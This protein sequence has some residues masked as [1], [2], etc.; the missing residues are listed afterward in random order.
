MSEIDIEVLAN[1]GAFRLDATAHFSARGITVVL[2]PSG[3]GKTTLLRVLAGLEKQV[4][5]S[6]RI[7]DEQWLDSKRGIR[8]ATHERSIGYIFQEARLFP[9]LSVKGN[10]DFAQRRGKRRARQLDRAQII[11]I[12]GIK[13]LLDR[14]C[15]AL[16]GGEIQRVAIAR[17]LLTN[18]QLLLMDEPLSALDLV[19]R[20]EALAY[21]E[22]IPDVFGIPI[23]YV[24][25]A[26]EEAS[27]VANQLAIMNNG[28]IIATGPAQEIVAR[29]DLAPYLGRF[30]AGAILE[31]TV[32]NE[33]PEFAIST[34]DL[35]GTPLQVPSLGLPKSCKVRLRIRARDVAIAV[36]RPEGISIR[37]VIAAQIEEIVEEEDSAF[38]ELRLKAMCQILRARITRRSVKELDLKP[39][40]DVFALIK[41][42]AVDRQ[43]IAAQRRSG[44]V[45]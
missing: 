41:S 12:L 42:I 6:I 44:Q 37:N 11:S 5:G 40:K 3:S 16:S 15:T 23:V 29:L 27:R 4:S 33:D 34:V 39:G 31:G 17:S 20:A 19:R 8:V 30:E 13:Q 28:R 7:G 43:L 2:G 24:T 10:L 26:I 45:S 35:D 18:P 14:R 38:A 9:H 36:K 25:H 1:R 22:R 21:I 32:T